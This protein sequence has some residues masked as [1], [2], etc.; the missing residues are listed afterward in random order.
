[1]KSVSKRLVTAEAQW[2]S[3][4]VHCDAIACLRELAFT[5]EQASL[6]G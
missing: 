3:H 4:M 6:I 5:D 2:L 1:M